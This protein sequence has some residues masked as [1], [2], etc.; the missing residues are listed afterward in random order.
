MSDDPR[1]DTSTL[2]LIVTVAVSQ[3]VFVFISVFL[4]IA[5]WFLVFR[6]LE[7]R[8]RR[9]ATRANPSPRGATRTDGARAAPAV[10]SPEERGG[11]GTAAGPAAPRLYEAAPAR[12]NAEQVGWWAALISKIV[13]YLANIWARVT[14]SSREE[15]AEPRASPGPAAD[16]LVAAGRELA[17]LDAKLKADLESFYR[18]EL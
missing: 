2:K 10:Q 3:A 5:A 11:S 6:R 7:S 9:R 4:V 17:A 12:G 15:R 14:R 13:S 18:R 16:R 1:R 8:V